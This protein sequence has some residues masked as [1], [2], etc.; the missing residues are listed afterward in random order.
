M[1]S[2]S[3]LEDAL[4]PIHH[5]SDPRDGLNA[6]LR[7]EPSLAPYQPLLEQLTELEEDL[8]ATRQTISCINARINE[9]TNQIQQAVEA[10]Q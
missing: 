6:V 5:A 7:S 2:P 3:S 4:F 1:T 10:G 8:R 9:L